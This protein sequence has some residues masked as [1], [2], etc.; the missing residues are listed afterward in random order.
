MSTERAEAALLADTLGIRDYTTAPVVPQPTTEVSRCPLFKKVL[1]LEAMT[2]GIFPKEPMLISLA[3][4]NGHVNI[5][6][7]SVGATDTTLVIDG[8]TSR[9]GLGIGHAGRIGSISHKNATESL[10]G[11]PSVANII[12]DIAEATSRI[13]TAL[14]SPPKG[15]HIVYK[16]T[17]V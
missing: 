15:S 6:R 17:S 7:T 4:E 1:I 8:R 11:I 5:L 13:R 2:D 12:A 10:S 16:P 14:S 9:F 3:F